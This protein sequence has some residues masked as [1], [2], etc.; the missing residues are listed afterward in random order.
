MQSTDC[1]KIFRKTRHARL[2]QDQRSIPEMAIEMLLKFGS[3]EPSH[4]DT[5]RL[6]FSDKDWKKV[7]RYFGA[8]MPNKA[9]Q[10]R[11]LYMVVSSDG[12]IVTVAHKH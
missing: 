5:E 4:D 8:W 12:A 11:D 2:R 7:K 1:L 6:Y 9:G 10:L 3:S